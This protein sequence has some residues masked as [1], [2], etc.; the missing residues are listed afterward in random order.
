[1]IIDKRP[2]I[3]SINVGYDAMV[4]SRGKM[5]VFVRYESIIVCVMIF[6]YESF[7]FEDIHRNK[8]ANY[9]SLQFS[10]TSVYRF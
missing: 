8:I 10:S 7:C 6:E 4:F 3:K 2:S 1:M 9:P 5:F